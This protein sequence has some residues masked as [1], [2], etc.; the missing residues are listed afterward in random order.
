VSCETTSIPS[1]HITTLS[2]TFPRSGATVRTA[3][4]RQSHPFTIIFHHE[5]RSSKTDPLCVFRSSYVNAVLSQLGIGQVFG[6]VTRGVI[7][8]LLGGRQDAIQ[9]ILVV[10]L[11]GLSSFNLIP[12]TRDQQIPES[13]SQCRGGGLVIVTTI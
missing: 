7:F 12:P 1:H 6:T 11:F 13:T 5:L 8:A 4:D 3:N 10:T 2:D 9:S